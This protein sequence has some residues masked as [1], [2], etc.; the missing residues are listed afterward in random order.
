MTRATDAIRRRLSAVLLLGAPLA[1]LAAFGANSARVPAASPTQL[2]PGPALQELRAALALMRDLQAQANRLRAEYARM[3]GQAGEETDELKRK[4][5]AMEEQIGKLEAAAAKIE[6]I[7]EAMTTI[8]PQLMAYVGADPKGANACNDVANELR[9]T[10]Y[11]EASHQA[12]IAARTYPW[13]STRVREALARGRV[14]LQ[15]YIR[16]LR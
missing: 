15:P 4:I 6:R 12:A 8:L 5:A 13:T 16:P 7:A 2:Q 11:I 9:V 3:K 14:S 1:P 10:G